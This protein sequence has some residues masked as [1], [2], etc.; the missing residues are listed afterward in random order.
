MY[1]TV[2]YCTVLYCTVLFWLLTRH[3]CLVSQPCPT[4][5]RVVDFAPV[6]P[7]AK[8]STTEGYCVVG[9]FQIHSLLVLLLLLLLLLHHHHHYFSDRDE[10]FIIF[11]LLIRTSMDAYCT[12]YLVLYF[13]S[14]YSY[15]LLHIHTHYYFTSMRPPLDTHHSLLATH[16]HT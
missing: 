4:I 6:V 12:W 10:Q 14:T 8:I 13:L 16:I 5:A 7:S 2:L 15:I 3:L 11:Y 1:I 9:F